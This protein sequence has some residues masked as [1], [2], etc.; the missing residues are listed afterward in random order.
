MLCQEV[1]MQQRRGEGRFVMQTCGAGHYGHVIITIE[2]PL[3]DIPFQVCWEVEETQIPQIYAS[4]VTE[5]LLQALAEV[6]WPAPLLVR[7]V[8]GSHH[9]VD[10]LAADYREAARRAMH[11]ASEGN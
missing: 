3:E 8:G 9:P 1:I 5:G 7:I 11:Q 6:R 2:P 10:S 4:A